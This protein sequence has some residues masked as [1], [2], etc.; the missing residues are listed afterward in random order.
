M[1][2][3]EFDQFRGILDEAFQVFDKPLNDSLVKSYWEALKDQPL[4]SVRR[5]AEYHT[6]HGKFCPRPKDLRPQDERTASDGGT[7]NEPA[8]VER[9]N[10]ES[11]DHW[12]A[13]LARD[14]EEARLRLRLAKASRAE[15]T[16]PLGTE[17]YAEAVDEGRRAQDELTRL[18]EERRA[19]VSRGT[20][21]LAELL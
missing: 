8:E 7:A 19:R 13:Y 16:M 12:A 5:R 11:A 1:H 20:S 2:L 4:A 9:I 21:A 14:P 18:W 17:A 3:S 15:A 6:R 10:R